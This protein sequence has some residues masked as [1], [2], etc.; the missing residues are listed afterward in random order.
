M[1]RKDRTIRIS[2]ERGSQVEAGQAVD[3]CWPSV[4]ELKNTAVASANATQ[5]QCS[6]PRNLGGATPGA[7]THTG[8]SS[9]VVVREEAVALALV[10]DQMHGMFVQCSGYRIALPVEAQF[11]ATLSDAR[12]SGPIPGAANPVPRN[13][14]VPR[15]KSKLFSASNVTRTV[16]VRGRSAK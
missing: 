15:R 3:G 2:H 8:N 12:Q 1:S 6:V 16:D 5:S 13:G 4:P 10:A 9:K 11:V 7:S 14:P